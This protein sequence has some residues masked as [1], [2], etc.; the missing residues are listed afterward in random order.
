MCYEDCEI[1]VIVSLLLQDEHIHGIVATVMMLLILLVKKRDCNCMNT[2]KKSMIGLCAAFACVSVANATEG[3]DFVN[4]FPDA[5]TW[6]M[7]AGKPLPSGVASDDVWVK[8]YTKDDGTAVKGYWRSAAN[9]TVNDNFSTLGNI[10]INPY[11]GELG[12]L[13]VSDDGTQVTLDLSDAAIDASVSV[14]SAIDSA[15]NAVSTM[16]AEI[17]T[18]LQIAQAIVDTGVTS[19]IT[20]D[21]LATIQE[22]VDAGVTAVTPGDITAAETLRD[23]GLVTAVTPEQILD[24]EALIAGDLVTAVTLAQITAAEALVNGSIE[25]KYTASQVINATFAVNESFSEVTGFTDTAGKQNWTAIEAAD[26]DSVNGTINSVVD[27]AV[28]VEEFRFTEINGATETADGSG[29]YGFNYYTNAEDNGGQ[30]STMTVAQRTAW[31]EAYYAKQAIANQDTLDAGLQDDVVMA[32]FIRAKMVV[33]A[34]VI[35]IVTDDQV[36]AAEV[37]LADADVVDYTESVS[38]SGTYTDGSRIQIDTIDH[39][40]AAKNTVK[41]NLTGNYT[42]AEIVAARDVRDAPSEHTVDEVKLAN[43]IVDTGIVADATGVNTKSVTLGDMVTAQGEIDKV[44]QDGYTVDQLIEAEELRV[45]GPI[46][47]AVTQADVD[48]AEAVLISGLVSTITLKEILEAKAITL[49]GQEGVTAEEFAAAEAILNNLQGADVN[50]ALNT[51]MAGE[52]E[53]VTA[54]QIAAAK[55]LV[56][57]GEV[58]GVT[59][60]QIFAAETLIAAGEVE[61]VSAEQIAAAKALVANGA[62]EEVTQEQVDAA[63]AIVDTQIAAQELIVQIFNNG[64]KIENPT[65][66]QIAAA[67]AKHAE[68][69]NKYGEN[70]VHTVVAT[71]SIADDDIDALQAIVETYNTYSNGVVDSEK[72]KRFVISGGVDAVKALVNTGH[73][74]TAL[75]HINI[76]LKDRSADTMTLNDFITKTR[77]DVSSSVSGSTAG[78]NVVGGAIGGHQQ[79]VVTSSGKYG[80]RKHSLSVSKQLGMSSGDEGRDTRAWLKVF[81]S[82][83]EM[84]MRDSVPGYD[85]DASGIVVGIDK[86]FGDLT[87]G[88]A[89]SVANIDVDGKSIANSKTD[90]DQYQ[91]TLYGTMMTESFY[92]N[93]SLA[94]GHASSDTSR[95]GLDGVVTGSYDTDIF[96]ASLGIGVPVDMGSMAII[97]QATMSYASISPDAYTESGIGALRVNAENMN[98]FGIKAGVAVISKFDFGGGVIAPQVRLMADWD[99]SQEKSVVNSSWVGDVDNTVYSTSGAEPA[100]LGAIIGTGF[101][102]ASDD[103][104]YVLSMGYDLSTRSD[105]VSHTGSAKFRVNF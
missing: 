95:N 2:M 27:S 67:Q 9:D 71:Y 56:A 8:S 24:A 81:G 41:N 14:A 20:T 45:T 54:E 83:S 53:G 42:L 80:L 86:T 15:T 84:D 63:Q 31:L 62:V 7:L 64:V 87:I 21:D 68:Y 36:T 76:A 61:G 16:V 5:G 55:I 19:A 78:V 79:S 105:F 74:E 43:V 40:I 66:E 3:W 100:S 29:V 82:D 47:E 11:T 104:A 94:Y 59:A 91:G 32:D 18:S 25:N 46:P 90:S 97:P 92:I 35:K 93:G 85:A 96:A 28:S 49:G 88:A 26:V 38:A 69:E 51:I 57:A 72:V 99:I 12:T 73:V 37:L 65:Q 22:F 75:K 98:S 44:V 6:A 10:N 52:I 60:E 48:A 70:T 103:G 89:I 17:E 34:G 30:A 1:E 101:D 50:A 58:E 23:N 4:T 39:L 77:P 13:D 33:D 102:Y